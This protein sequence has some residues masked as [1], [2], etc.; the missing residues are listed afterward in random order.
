MTDETAA[1]TAGEP[2]TITEPE[3]D[4]APETALD[5]VPVFL[6][7]VNPS[8]ALAG[9]TLRMRYPSVG[10]LIAQRRGI[11][12]DPEWWEEVIDAIEEHD[13][14]RTPESLPA[15]IVD[16]IGVAWVAAI[17]ERAIPPA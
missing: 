13:L 5:P 10:F 1:A 15:A 3:A 4:E 6:L 8:G 17:K 12:K 16:E 14:G 11:A 2:K 9:R 7:T